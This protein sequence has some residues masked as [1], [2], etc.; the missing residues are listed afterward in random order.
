MTST[1][2]HPS[3]HQR[4]EVEPALEAGLRG[5]SWPAGAIPAEQPG[6]GPLS[7]L[8]PRGRA[9][10]RATLA[11][12]ACAVLAMWWL[13]TTGRDLH[14]IG[15]QLTAAGRISGLLGAY[16]ALTQLALLARVPWFERAVGF[17]RLAAWH[18][19]LGTNTVLLIVA[20]PVLIIWGYGLAA[21]RPAPSQRVAILTT[22]P[23]MLKATGGLLA[24]VVVAVTS[25]QAARRRL[26]Y[27]S[28]YWLHLS[29]YLAAA[30]A[31]G[32]Q[33]ANGVDF[34]GHPINQLL[35]KA[36]YGVVA[37]CLLVWRVVL[38]VRRVLRHR[39]RVDQ[40]V[41]EGPGVVSVW[42]RGA[43]LDELGASAG[44]FFL[45][46]FLAGGHLWSAHPYSLSAVPDSRQLR[47]PSRTLET[48]LAGWPGC[49][50]G[51]W[52]SRRVRSAI[53]LPAPA[54]AEGCC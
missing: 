25:A 34:V 47:S 52:C 42:L 48:T 32:H 22:Y 49:G 24:F 39:L 54:P 5:W 31:F 27:E 2:W 43:H 17:D 33:L 36:L 11:A 50:R 41:A 44:Q 3:W 37:G 16:L 7:S 18:R 45:W 8:R 21:G 35:W 9:L 40:V 30:L 46:R 10:V 12:G 13:D 20:H 15:G 29:A 14:T 6:V 23:N 19:A 38:P 53:S 28:W 4:G 1:S 51:P 26:S